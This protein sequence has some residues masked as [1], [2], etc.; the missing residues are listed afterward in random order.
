MPTST[1]LT[2]YSFKSQLP[3]NFFKNIMKIKTN[4]FKKVALN[5][6]TLR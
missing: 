2:N 4:K 1:N 3:K 6:N 5:D